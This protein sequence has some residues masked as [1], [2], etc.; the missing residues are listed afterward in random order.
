MHKDKLII[1][2]GKNETALIIDFNK[3]FIQVL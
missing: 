3:H 1:A 2:Y